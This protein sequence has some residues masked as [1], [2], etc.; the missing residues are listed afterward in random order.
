MGAGP[1]AARAFERRSQRRVE[2]QEAVERSDLE[3]LPHD[4]IRTRDRNARVSSTSETVV[5]LHKNSE[6]GGVDERALRQV[7]DDAPRSV[8]ERLR[9]RTLQDGAGIEVELALNSDDAHIAVELLELD[10]QLDLLAHKR[11]RADTRSFAQALVAAAKRLLVRH[12]MFL[13]SGHDRN[14]A[15]P[16]K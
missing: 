11:L 4:R 10:V 7:D 6:A 13:P 12:E 16:S 14:G 1:L 3:D 15:R 9:Q 5:R 8:G 2:H